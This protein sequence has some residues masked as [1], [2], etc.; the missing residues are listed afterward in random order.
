MIA[1]ENF[2]NP[3]VMQAMGSV[4]T[5]KYAEVT[6]IKDIMVDVSLLIKLSN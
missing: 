1:S 6:Q 2:T 5:N 4:F 3:A